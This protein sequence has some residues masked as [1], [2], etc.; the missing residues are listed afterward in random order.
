MQEYG[1]SLTTIFL[2]T[3]KYESDKPH[4]LAY[5]REF[6]KGKIFIY[7]MQCCE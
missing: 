2:D 4:I 3:E 7:L 5:F 1:F 6:S